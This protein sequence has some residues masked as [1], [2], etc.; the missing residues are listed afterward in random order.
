MFNQ[1]I[2][3][4]IGTEFINACISNRNGEIICKN[5]VNLPSPPMPG[6]VTVAICFLIE[7]ID[8]ARKVKFVGV[9]I[10]GTLDDQRRVVQSFEDN[11]SW[12]NVPLFNWLEIRLKRKLILCTSS[13]CARL[14]KYWNVGSKDLNKE[15]ILTLG[16]ARKAFESF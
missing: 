1:F 8:E 10:K 3:I 16:A 15:Y 13:E 6:A 12:W 14:T 2:G 9:G 4:Y 5:Q 11:L 7:S